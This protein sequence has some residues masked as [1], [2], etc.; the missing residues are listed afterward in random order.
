MGQKER[1]WI[2]R[3][4]LMTQ[5]LMSLQIMKRQKCILTQLML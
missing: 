4:E 1:E 5:E 2:L 3:Q